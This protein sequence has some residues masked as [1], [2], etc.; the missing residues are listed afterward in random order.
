MTKN[1]F[2]LKFLDFFYIKTQL[3]DVYYLVTQYYPDETLH[4]L[5]SRKCAINDPFHP[6]KIKEWSKQLLN[7]TNYL[8][9]KNIIHRDIKPSNIF[10]NGPNLVIG[11]LGHAKHFSNRVSLKISK[12]SYMYGTDSY[13][14]PESNDQGYSSKI[15]IWSFGCVLFEMIKLKRLFDQKTKNELFMKIFTFDV[16]KEFDQENI[17]PFFIT[18]L[19]KYV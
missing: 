5:I 17:E 15:D 10:I 12:I 9:S 13:N 1:E 19:K 4:H 6:D 8:H 16:D 18:I 7:G 3:G 2:I 14:A 11:D